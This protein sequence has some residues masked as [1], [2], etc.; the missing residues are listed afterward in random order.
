M[1]AALKTIRQKIKEQETKLLAVMVPQFLKTKGFKTFF[2]HLSHHHS[3]WMRIL[4]HPQRRPVLLVLSRAHCAWMQRNAY[5]HKNLGQTDIYRLVNTIVQY[6][7]TADIN[8]SVNILQYEPIL[9]LFY[10][11]GKMLG[12]V[13]KW[14]KYFKSHSADIIHVWYWPICLVLE[15]SCLLTL[16]LALAPKI[17]YGSSST[18]DATQKFRPTE[19]KFGRKP[20]TRKKLI[21]ISVWSSWPGHSGSDSNMTKTLHQF[22][23]IHHKLSVS[24]AVQII[25]TTT[26]CLFIKS[27]WWMDDNMHPSISPAWLFRFSLSLALFGSPPD[28]RFIGFCCCSRWPIC[29]FALYSLS[30]LIVAFAVTIWQEKKANTK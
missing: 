6:S 29:L 23:L 20:I 8:I 27:I 10:K 12:L 21:K 7:P 26:S 24:L 3:E 4:E 30:E 13:I 16:V 1:S 5:K 11:A 18:K 15:F 14:C 2:W 19:K 22:W 28:H 17:P 25:R 9:K